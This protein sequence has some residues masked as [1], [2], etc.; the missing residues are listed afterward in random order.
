MHHS[1]RRLVVTALLVTVGGLLVAA[2]AGEIS[3]SGKQ[4]VVNGNAGKYKMKG[5]LL[6]KWKITK[7]KQLHAPPHFKGKGKERFNGCIDTDRDRSC[8]GEPSG[9]MCSKFR[10]WAQVDDQGAVQLGTCAHRVTGGTGS[11][12]SASGFVM[13]VDTPIGSPPF[14]KTHYEGEINLGQG[15]AAP[16]GPA[17]ADWLREIVQPAGRPP[18]PGEPARCG[19]SGRSRHNAD[20]AKTPPDILAS[21]RKRHRRF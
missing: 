9:K 12:A 18:D 19:L 16:D 21:R 15:R 20:L 10:Y 3:V 14:I 7:F 6:G 13:M 11:F 2:P 17:R 8:S 1:P 4:K 5:D